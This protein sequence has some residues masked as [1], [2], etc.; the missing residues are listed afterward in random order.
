MQDRALTGPSLGGEMLRDTLAWAARRLL[1][2]LGLGL[3]FWLVSLESR[4]LDFPDYFGSASIIGAFAGSG[5]GLRTVAPASNQG[6]MGPILRQ[7]GV[8]LIA[9]G[10]FAALFE[11]P[12]LPS[13]VTF[14]TS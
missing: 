12:T 4:T 13:L 9:L 11:I 5:W 3:A 1:E 6:W 8:L 10:L 2:A 7:V 14:C